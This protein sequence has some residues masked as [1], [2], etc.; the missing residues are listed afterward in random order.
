VVLAN[1]LCLLCINYGSAVA[2][3]QVTLRICTCNREGFFGCVI[4][5]FVP[6]CVPA[7]D[8]SHSDISLI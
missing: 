8:T 2:F 5:M 6:A 1:G 4:E 3:V 7:T